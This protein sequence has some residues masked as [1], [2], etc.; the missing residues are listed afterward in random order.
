MDLLRER[1][2]GF[3]RLL[4]EI[5]G[6]L[7]TFKQVYTCLRQ[8]HLMGVLLHR[9]MIHLEDSYTNFRLSQEHGRE[10]PIVVEDDDSERGRSPSPLMVRVERQDTV[11]PQGDGPWMI[12][13]DD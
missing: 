13:I 2:A 1:E 7:E 4:L 3:E 10:N 12:E 8:F 11:V 5:E 6:R 9:R